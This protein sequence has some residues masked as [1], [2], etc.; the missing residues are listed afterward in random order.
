VTRETLVATAA[1]AGVHDPAFAVV[2]IRAVHFFNSRQA[3][4]QSLRAS[5]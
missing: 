2:A 3:T 5:P 4:M 1:G